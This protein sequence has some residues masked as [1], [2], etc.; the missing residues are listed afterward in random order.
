[1]GMS[2]A[3]YVNLIFLSAVR[4]IRVRLT[5]I[6]RQVTSE[7]DWY[8][9]LTDSRTDSHRN[10]LFTISKLHDDGTMIL[11]SMAEEYRQPV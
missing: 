8:E 3:Q 6:W 11:A 10:C 2:S 7:D 5:I 4:A 1:M 9:T